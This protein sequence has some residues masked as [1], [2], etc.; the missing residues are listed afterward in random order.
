MYCLDMLFFSE[1]F[2]YE[3]LEH[4][5]YAFFLHNKSYDNVDDDLVFYGTLFKSYGDAGRM[6]KKSH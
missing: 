5:L 1:S 6:I 4:L 3:I 2:L